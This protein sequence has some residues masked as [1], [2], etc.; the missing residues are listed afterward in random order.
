MSHHADNNVRWR[1]PARLAPTSVQRYEISRTQLSMQHGLKT[2]SYKT[3]ALDHL[4]PIQRCALT[5]ADPKTSRVVLYSSFILSSWVVQKLV[6]YVRFSHQKN[7]WGKQQETRLSSS[8]SSGCFQLPSNRRK[9]L[10][11][12]TERIIFL[13]WLYSTGVIWLVLGALVRGGNRMSEKTRLEEWLLNQLWNPERPIKQRTSC[14]SVLVTVLLCTR[15]LN[16]CIIIPEFMQGV[17]VLV[18]HRCP[19]TDSRPAKLPAVLPFRFGDIY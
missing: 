4:A 19:E 16:A 9:Y 3:L 13:P 10:L 12:K 6:S 18:Y 2:K 1:H 5:E 11:L 15:Q 14:L 17:E 7:V 8:S